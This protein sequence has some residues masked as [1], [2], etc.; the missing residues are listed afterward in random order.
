MA[1]IKLIE[2]YQCVHS[3]LVVTGVGNGVIQNYRTSGF[4]PLQRFFEEKGCV[5]YSRKLADEFVAHSLDAYKNDLIPKRRYQYIRKTV[6]LLDECQNTGTIKWRYL[7]RYT[8]PSLTSKNFENTLA[9]YLEHMNR[10]GRYAPMSLKVY[11]LAIKQFLH[12]LEEGGYRRIRCLTRTIVSDYIP[13]IAKRRPGSISLVI[14][15]L[16]SFLNYLHESKHIAS[17]L[18]SVLH[19]SP[20]KRRKHFAGFTRKEANTL[21]D[22]VSSDR[23][24]DKR[25]IAVF[26]LAESTGL[27]AVDVANL[28]LSDIDWRNKTISIIQQKTCHPLILPFENRVGDAIAEYILHGRPE[29][30]SP[31][32]F[33]SDRR[34]FRPVS[35]NALSAAALKYIKLSGIEN[36]LS[37]R[38][39]FHCFRRGIGTWLLE[40][41]LPLTMISEILGHGNIDSTKPYLSTDLDRLRECA[42]GLGGIEIR[43]GVFQ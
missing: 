41:E 43:K 32:I 36:N 15:A 24:Y 6:A 22:S 40:A 21:I 39:G 12:Y 7:S 33:L 38:K 1:K 29:S 5:Y 11:R 20:K 26:T 16:K 31:F 9:R 37:L 13:I 30:D 19:G 18:V 17:D 8:T 35:A 4:R 25:N 14:T 2:L 34:P 3:S 27:R 23:H 42:I 10:E 28:K